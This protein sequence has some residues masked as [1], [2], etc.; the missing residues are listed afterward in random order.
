MR[1]LCMLATAIALC[2]PACAPED[3]GE[4]APA[5][6]EA[7]D[8]WHAWAEAEVA[9][10][11]RERPEFAAAVLALEPTVTRADTLRFTGPVVRDADAAPLFLHRFSQERDPAV[12]AAL[13]EA[14]PRT[15]GRYADALGDLYAAEGDALVREVLVASAWRAPAD[16]ALA[17]I[18][19]ALADPA[20]RVRATAAHTASRHTDGARLTGALA[21]R[22]SDDAAPVRAAAARALGVHG[23]AQAAAL[24][25]LLAD[26]DADVRLAALRA[27]DR[28]G[29]IAADPA[30]AARLTADPD[31]RVRRLAARIASEV[32]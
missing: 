1:S 24:E 9:R 18:E 29:A 13:A 26:A 27:L 19:A 21:E 4:A 22:L 3:G 20:P 30:P 32:H 25:P 14:L 15:G 31:P 12:R 16:D 6:I 8:D 10:L 17:V 7:G 23:V 28:T 11:S 2:V 5:A